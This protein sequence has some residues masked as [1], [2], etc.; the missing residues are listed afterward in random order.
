MITNSI[1]SNG[2]HLDSSIEKNSSKNTQSHC[3]LWVEIIRDTK[4]L[5]EIGDKLAVWSKESSNLGGSEALQYHTLVEGISEIVSERLKINES[6]KNKKFMIFAAYDISGNLQG[7]EVS[8]LK[9]KN[10]NIVAMKVDLL[11]I[12][13]YNTNL[14]SSE[15]F[16]KIRGTGTCLL[17]RTIE[18]LPAHTFLYLDPLGKSYKFYIHI[19][20]HVSEDY[21]GYVIF[22]T[23]ELPKLKSKI[24]AQLQPTQSLT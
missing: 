13:I 21:P 7:I 5:T 9:K 17:T 14:F 22:R 8:H 23:D 18:M 19:G 24:D 1:I 4:R 15:N 20:F 12:S 10:D 3:P 6:E 16:T 11:I 2:Q